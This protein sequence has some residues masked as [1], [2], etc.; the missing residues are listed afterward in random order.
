VGNSVSTVVGI[1]GGSGAGKTTFV[2]RLLEALPPGS[3][4]TL[5]HDTYYRDLSHLPPDVRAS[6]NFDHP[7]S[8][9]TAL[10]CDHV[11]CL[12]R[13]IG[14]DVPTYDFATH[15]RS[16]HTTRAEPTPTL[17]VEGILILA[18]ERLRS[19]LGLAVYIDVE[20]DARLARRIQRDIR[21]R[22]RS[23]ES[24]TRQWLETVQPM[25][26]EFVGPSRGHAD[27]I[28]PHGGD[29]AMAA[30]LLA[31]YASRQPQERL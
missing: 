1:A 16:G 9:E 3:T 7:D 10:L 28:V 27:I 18:D 26:D 4:T 19:L 23:A 21:D 6:M 22:G 8:L 20:P 24:V 2:R 31:A 14:V 11:D 12:R 25:H 15:S 29:N 13:G 17:I 5:S 30:R